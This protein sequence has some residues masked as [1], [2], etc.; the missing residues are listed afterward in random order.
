MMFNPPHPGETLYEQ[1][2]V[3]LGITV[4]E[5]ARRLGLTRA[6]LSRV[7]HG[8]AGV[9][10]DLAVRLERAGISSARFWLVR[11]AQYDLAQAE[12]RTQPQVESLRELEPA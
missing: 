6:A 12:A 3:P 9:S 1:V 7:L 5:A 4:T 10:P 11:Q 2:I 8:H